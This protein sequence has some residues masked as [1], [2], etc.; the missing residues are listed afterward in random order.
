VPRKTLCESINFIIFRP[1]DQ[2]LWVSENFR[3]SLDRAGPSYLTNYGQKANLW[4]FWTFSYGGKLRILGGNRGVRAVWTRILPR[5]M[6]NIER[7]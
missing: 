4:T 6:R 2:K 3:R 7:T 5:G 1:M